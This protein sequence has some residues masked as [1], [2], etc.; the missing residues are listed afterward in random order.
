MSESSLRFDLQA[1][2]EVDLQHNMKTL[3]PITTGLRIHVDFQGVEN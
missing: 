2:R 1:D 3:Q